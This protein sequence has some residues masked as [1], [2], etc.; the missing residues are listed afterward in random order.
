M[1]L[2]ACIVSIDERDESVDYSGI[3]LNLTVDPL[4]FSIRKDDGDR[5]FLDLGFLRLIRN[6]IRV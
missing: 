1:Y 5:V 6:S 4:S 3:K 2:G